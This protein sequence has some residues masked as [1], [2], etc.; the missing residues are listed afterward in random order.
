M[1]RATFLVESALAVAFAMTASPAACATEPA[2][3]AIYKCEIEGV[4]TFSDRPC[5]DGVEPHQVG[6]TATNTYEAPAVAASSRPKPKTH[7]RKRAPRED[8]SEAKR[9]ESCAR[10][11]RSLKEIRSR[12]RAGY[13]AKEGERLRRR[14]D[15]LRESQRVQRCG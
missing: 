15:Q 10:H 3:R 4:T 9:A 14:Q 12:M 8:R 7:A 13:S 5:G 1:R 11:A 2:A 6:P